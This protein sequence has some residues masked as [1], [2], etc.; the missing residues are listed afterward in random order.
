LKKI[1]LICALVVAVSLIPAFALDQTNN[2]TTNQTSVTNQ[3]PIKNQTHL[4]DKNC[5][6][7]CT[8]DCNSSC[9]AGDQHKYQHGQK[10]IANSD[11]S[12]NQEQNKYGLKN[13]KPVSGKGNMYQNCP[14][15]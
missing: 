4:R 5:T 10:N 14:K 3:T 6:Q 8:Q 9:G 11:T 1:A 12:K 7:N 13:T 2:T 15:N